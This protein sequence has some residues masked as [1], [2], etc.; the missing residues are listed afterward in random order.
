M[1]GFVGFTR[2]S[3]LP[4]RLVQ[5]NTKVDRT[6]LRVTS[7]YD[8]L[9]RVILGTGVGMKAE[10][11]EI[12]NETTRKTTMTGRYPSG[13]DTETELRAVET[14][15]TEAGVD[16]LRPDV[17]TDAP[18][19]S[20]QTCPRD[21]GFMIEDLFFVARSKFG[22]RNAEMPGIERIIAH[23]PAENVVQTP[24]DHHLEG[25]DVVL[26]P[27]LVYVGLGQR[28]NLKA[29]EWLAA[30]LAARGIERDVVL[31]RHEALHLDCCWNVIGPD[32]ALWC[33]EVAPS[34]RT[35]SGDAYYPSYQYLRLTRAEQAALA[36]NVLCVMPGC[37][38]GR[39]DP[40]CDRIQSA[41][42]IDFNYRVISLTFDCVPSLGGSFRCAT[43]PLCR[44]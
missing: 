12:I 20:D 5:L 31:V 28:S 44:G 39:A 4:S 29:I 21:L 38:I 13:I 6:L 11:T 18:L 30:T 27:G 3:H 22:S 24:P 32:V 23:L 7:E 15:L 35:I 41:L 37:I 2:R 1:K 26:A 43:L 33:P 40:A 8:T 14:T 34:M 36:A 17:L 25:G 16:V 10:P 19:V 42:K 9:K